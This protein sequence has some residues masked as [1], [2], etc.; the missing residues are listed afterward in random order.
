MHCCLFITTVGAAEGLEDLQA[1]IDFKVLKLT[2]SRSPPSSWF[3]PFGINAK[4]PLKRKL[5]KY[6]TFDME[7]TCKAG[8][9]SLL[10]S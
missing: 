10:L 1:T 6:V 7:K 9:M 2:D 5:E 8:K 3:Y 4:I